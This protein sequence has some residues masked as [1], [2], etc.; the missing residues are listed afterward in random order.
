MFLALS[1][2]S[3]PQKRKSILVIT[4]V[5]SSS[6]KRL[7]YEALFKKIIKIF[8]VVFW[9]CASFFFEKK[10]HFFFEKK[11]AFILQ[12]R[13]WI[14]CKRRRL[15]GDVV[16]VAACFLFCLLGQSLEKEK[17]LFITEVLS[18]SVKR[19]L[20]EALLK[21]KKILGVMFWSSAFCCRDFG[22][23]VKKEKMLQGVFPTQ[24]KSR[25]FHTVCYRNEQCIDLLFLV[26]L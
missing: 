19:L 6:V 16:V 26:A 12:Q 20:Y 18:S 8:G 13:F 10:K 1:F 2:D 21:K 24:M 14:F 3:K 25:Q 15:Q 11:R 9:L 17:I 7:L 23:F 22:S 5:L 4:K